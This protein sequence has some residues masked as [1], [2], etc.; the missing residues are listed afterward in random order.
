MPGLIL[1]ASDSLNSWQSNISTC[2]FCLI[3]SV[4]D[5]KVNGNSLSD[6]LVFFFF[7]VPFGLCYSICAD[8]RVS[9]VSIKFYLF[10]HLFLSFLLSSLYLNKFVFAFLLP[11]KNN[12]YVKCFKSH[13]LWYLIVTYDAYHM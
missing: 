2:L 12:V 10:W 13:W 4:C 8:K 3:K 6:L 11:W 9:T 7:Q 1:W 5:L